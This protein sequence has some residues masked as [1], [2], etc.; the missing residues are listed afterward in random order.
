MTSEDWAQSGPLKGFLDTLELVARLAGAAVYAFE[1]SALGDISDEGVLVRMRHRGDLL[2]PP[3]EAVGGIIQVVRTTR[4]GGQVPGFAVHELGPL[5]VVLAQRGASDVLFHEVEKWLEKQI[6]LVATSARERA[7]ADALAEGVMVVDEQGHV[8]TCTERAASILGAS[9]A[10]IEGRLLSEILPRAP[11]HLEPNEV[12]RGSLD[13]GPQHTSFTVR[14]LAPNPLGAELPGLV[15]KLRDDRRFEGQRK[16]YLRFLSALRHDVRSPLTALK[17]LVSVL[18]D[19]PEMSTEERQSLLALLKQEAERTVTWV[20]DY[21]LILRVR[22]ESRPTQLLQMPASVIAEAIVRRFEIHAR[23]RRIELQLAPTPATG[24]VQIPVDPGLLEAF[25]N[26]LLGHFLRLGDAGAKVEVALEAQSDDRAPA[27]VIRGSGPGLFGSHPAEPFMTL[28]R[29]TAS[30]KRTP[31]VGLG[32]FLVKKVADVHGW[33]VECEV[34]PGPG[35]A[36]LQ[37][38]VDWGAD[39]AG[40]LAR[41]GA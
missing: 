11:T 12:A 37:V 25:G 31:G 1:K 39:R 29:S 41:E 13:E 26:N 2:V 22:F 21:L 8:V 4:K 14:H 27:L 23:E 32:L 7:A 34:V 36:V 6:L 9:C 24:Q 18:M 38:K 20:E 3:D 10:T 33:K 28:A 16:R 17:G 5:M 30:G 35:P 15:V 40:V 19:E